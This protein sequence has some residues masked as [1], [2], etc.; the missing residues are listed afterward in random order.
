MQGCRALF[1]LVGREHSPAPLAG[2]RLLGAAVP[3]AL[4]CGREVWDTPCVTA[5]PLL[6]SDSYLQALERD[7][8]VFINFSPRLLTSAALSLIFRIVFF[9]IPTP[10]PSLSSPF[11]QALWG[12]TLPIC[13]WVESVTWSCHDLACHIPF[14]LPASAHSSEPLAQLCPCQGQV[15][16][17]ASPSCSA[18]SSL[19]LGSWLR[20]T[21]V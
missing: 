9:T 6:K 16:L 17:C 1:P 11:N 2:A 3:C 20:M 12:G 4:T 14:S 10:K 13:G 7:K 15:W 18:L 19:P 5:S 21:L 8:V